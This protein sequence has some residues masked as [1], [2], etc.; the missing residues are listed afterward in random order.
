MEKDGKIT[1]SPIQLATMLVRE[2]ENDRK[3]G[4]ERAPLLD[5]GLSRVCVHVCVVFHFLTLLSQ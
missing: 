3:R 4:S 1:E 5:S 2:R